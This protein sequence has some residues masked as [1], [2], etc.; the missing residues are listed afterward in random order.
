MAIA[1]DIDGTLADCGHRLQFIKDL[2]QDWDRF[3]EAM[4]RDKVIE[5]MASMI[6]DLYRSNRIILMT[7][8]PEKY[9]DMTLEWLIRN[10]IPF[11]ELLMRPDDDHRP[12]YVLK[13]EMLWT[14]EQMGY[15]INL[16]IDDKP[17]VVQMFLQRGIVC[18]QMP[19][20]KTV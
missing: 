13:S 15:E 20:G 7:G 14:A 9:R 18:L 11:T 2:P 8:R 5:P 17:A 4:G 12:D 19:E 1:V 10:Y 6:K 3:Y 16:A